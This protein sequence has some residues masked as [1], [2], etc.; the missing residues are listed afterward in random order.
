MTQEEARTVV[1]SEWLKLHPDLRA[2]EKQRTLFAKAA[3]ERHRFPC[4]G[5]RVDT[6]M[7]WLEA[8]APDGA[9]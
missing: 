9:S 4:D 2:T 1:A 7:A 6:I 8:A 5:G 3:E